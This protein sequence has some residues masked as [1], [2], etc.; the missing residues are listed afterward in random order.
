MVLQFRY[1]ASR[2]SDDQANNENDSV[3]RE[4]TQTANK[5]KLPKKTSSLNNDKMPTTRSMTNGPP[6]NA[7]PPCT[8]QQTYDFGILRPNVSLKVIWVKSQRKQLRAKKIENFCGD[9]EN[10]WSSF[11]SLIQTSLLKNLYNF[12]ETLSKK[13][14]NK[15]KFK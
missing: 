10:N 8:R 7:Q 5:N 4:S 6:P 9:K 14:F 11:K 13:C 3:S 15:K 12:F 2:R 1:F